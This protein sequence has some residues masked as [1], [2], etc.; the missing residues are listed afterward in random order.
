LAVEVKNPAKGTLLSFN[1]TVV[2]L[3]DVMGSGNDVVEA[4]YCNCCVC[5][6][7]FELRL[8]VWTASRVNQSQTIGNVVS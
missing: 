1:T 6:G 4:G 3:H 2:F 5:V 7:N 8:L